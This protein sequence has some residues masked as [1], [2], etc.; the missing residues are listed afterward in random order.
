MKT[1]RGAEKRDSDFKDRNRQNKN[2]EEGRISTKGVSR[3]GC[4]DN[5]S[6]PDTPPYLLLYSPIHILLY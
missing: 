4:D 2:I 1:K 5:E 6:N 3:G